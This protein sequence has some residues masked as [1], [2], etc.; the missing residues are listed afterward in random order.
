[1]ITFSIESEES[2]NMHELVQELHSLTAN[3][4]NEYKVNS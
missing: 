2:Q 1:M 3:T 4:P